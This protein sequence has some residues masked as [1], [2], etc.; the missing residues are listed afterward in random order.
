MKVR[1]KVPITIREAWTSPTGIT[2]PAGTLF[3]ESATCGIWDY[4]APDGS[5]GI[6]NLLGGR[7][8]EN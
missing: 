4:K 2:F 7:P 3:V 8:G 5:W 6:A 1:T